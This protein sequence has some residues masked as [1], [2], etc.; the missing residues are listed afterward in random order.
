MK[1]TEKEDQTNSK[2]LPRYGLKRGKFLR[3]KKTARGGTEDHKHI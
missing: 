2:H 3:R 1:L